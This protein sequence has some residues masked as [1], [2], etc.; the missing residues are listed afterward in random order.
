MIESAA[1]RSTPPR[2]HFTRV[3]F[4]A[5]TRSGT[6]T[7]RKPS[8]PSR[9]TSLSSALGR[10]QIR[11]FP[12]MQSRP[13]PLQV[14]ATFATCTRW[15]PSLSSSFPSLS[16]SYVS[17]TGRRELFGRVECILLSPRALK[18]NWSFRF[19][20]IQDHY[21][22]ET[23]MKLPICRYISRRIQQ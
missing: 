10:W 1:P 8:R 16:A 5:P 20:S 22:R 2:G 11:T 3:R 21:R 18:R 13:I 17:P 19:V 4:V 23:R 14:H 9:S 7:P 15:I 12:Q 6:P